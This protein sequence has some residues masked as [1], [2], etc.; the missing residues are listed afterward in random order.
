MPD[1]NVGALTQIF[2]EY[3]PD[4]T[5]EIIG[6]VVTEVDQIVKEVRYDGWAATQKGDRLVRQEIRNTLRKFQLHTVTGL[7]EAA[8][9]YIKV[10][11]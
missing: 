7:F 8:Y 4:N 5:P 2:N 1:P 6:R 11:Y 9:D 10:H 3:A